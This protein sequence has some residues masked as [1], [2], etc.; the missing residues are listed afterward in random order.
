[1]REKWA[2]KFESVA[3]QMKIPA[4]GEE[5]GG[6]GNSLLHEGEVGW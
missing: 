3:S 1:V 5:K 4:R 6:D 2:G